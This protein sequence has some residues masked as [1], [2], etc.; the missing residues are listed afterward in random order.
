MLRG[1]QLGGHREVAL[2]RAGGV[3]HDDHEATLPKV[4]GSFLDG[5]EHLRGRLLSLLIDQFHGHRL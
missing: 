4:L 2:V 3:V 5:R 1:D